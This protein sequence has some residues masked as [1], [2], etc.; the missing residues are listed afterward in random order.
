MELYLK[1]ARRGGERKETKEEKNGDEEQQTNCRQMKSERERGREIEALIERQIRGIEKKKKKKICRKNRQIQID[2]SEC[3]AG[4][5]SKNGGFLPTK[6]V[7]Y[8]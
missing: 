3:L 2:E 6:Y 8:F 1:S 7:C 5:A 4:S